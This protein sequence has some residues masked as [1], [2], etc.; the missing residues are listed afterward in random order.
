MEALGIALF[1]VSVILGIIIVNFGYR[2]YMKI[3][4]AD[5]MYYSPKKK[6]I[7][8]I[9]VSGAIWM[10]MLKVFIGGFV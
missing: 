4:G 1:V 7:Y 3:L 6:L 10:F 9:I 2:L 5:A 8:I